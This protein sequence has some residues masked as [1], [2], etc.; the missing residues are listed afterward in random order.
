MTTTSL[1][2]FLWK[3]TTVFAPLGQRR[4]FRH[5]FT[6]VELLIAIAIIGILISLL[7]PAVQMARESA[8]RS[9]CSDH[10]RQLG[11]ACL[12]HES[13]LKQL[14]TNG[15]AYLWVG[16]PDRG[17]QLKQPGGWIFNILPYTEQQQ[18]YGLQAGT[19]GDT[20]LAA[21]T[22]M[23]QTPVA[24]IICP[25]RRRVQL[26]AATEAIGKA[27]YISG[28]HVEGLASEAR[29][30]YASNGG[31]TYTDGTYTGL[32][33]YK[34]LPSDTEAID[35]L[36]GTATLTAGLA[37]LGEKASGVFYAGSNVTLDNITDGASNTYLCGE[38]YVQADHY[39]D[40]EDEGDQKCAYV[41]DD[42]DI[43]RWASAKFSPGQDT[44]GQNQPRAFGSAHAG[45]FNMCFCDGSVRPISYG[46]SATTHAYLANRRDGQ[47]IDVSQLNQ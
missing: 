23:I 28:G 19:T 44:A 43:T 40:G 29:S 32:F 9:Q 18:L 22:T 27:F 8:R 10:L 37:K 5:G 46:I 12:H 41:G 47:S 14:P 20:R 26:F 31:D 15:W 25:S 13:A 34:F 45:A 7:L 30:D 4:L 11:L 6:I 1:G 38:K 16:D 21:A 17:A 39:E 2:H 24:T 33:N 36:M 42:K 3:K 35:A